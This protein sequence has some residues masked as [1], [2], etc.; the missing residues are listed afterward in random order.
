MRA[1]QHHLPMITRLVQVG[2]VA[3]WLTMTVWLVRTTWFPDESRFEDVEL[4]E[5]MNAMFEN[6]N[7]TAELVILENGSEVGRL[8]VSATNARDDDNVPP[9]HRLSSV[10]SLSEFGALEFTERGGDDSGAA[11]A[12]AA[13]RDKFIWRMLVGLDETFS[14]ADVELVLRFPEQ[15]SKL[16]L[17]YVKATEEIAVRAIVNGIPAVNLEGKLSDFQ[18]SPPGIGLG[19]GLP[20]PFLAPSPGGT[21]QDNSDAM[22][23]SLSQWLLPLVSGNT[24]KNG[25]ANFADMLPRLTA[26]F[27]RTKI[28]GQ[29]LAVYLVLVT[30]PSE[31]DAHAKS[32]NSEKAVR[33][34][35]GEDGR[36]V[37]IDTPFGFEAIAEVM[38]AD[39]VSQADDSEESKVIGRLP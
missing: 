9:R 7:E 20:I 33:L 28:A 12:I 23:S 1:A 25:T 3:L 2:V 31:N 8:S 14:F 13:R 24:D 15:S 17:N 19:M 22:L 36:P 29:S 4:R 10:G 30:L 35:I 38:V 34:Y 26:K 5:V 18:S 32:A 21:S 16:E 6:W 39:Q 27:G 11:A 37:L